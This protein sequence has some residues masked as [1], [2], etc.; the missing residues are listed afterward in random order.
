MAH[1]A[2][3][4]RASQANCGLMA[5]RRNPP[6]PSLT[7][8]LSKRTRSR[9]RRFTSRSDAHVVNGTRDEGFDP[10]V[11]I[12]RLRRP[13][14]DPGSEWSP[15]QFSLPTPPFAFALAPKCSLSP[16]R[17]WLL[18]ADRQQIRPQRSRVTALSRKGQLSV[19][20]RNGRGFSRT[21]RKV[22]ASPA[23]GR[24]RPDL[25]SG[26]CSTLEYPNVGQPPFY[27]RSRDSTLSRYDIFPSLF[28]SPS[29][30]IQL[31]LSC[32]PSPAG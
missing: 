5:R 24:G 11:A 6:R 7:G 25:V 21:V 12:A 22:P 13:A 31:Y 9:H 14:S 15:S 27:Y 32:C 29:P 3:F 18:S 28:L 10:S 30:P 19:P 26:V 17:V 2:C 20:N 8:T 1:G 4:R 23:A 16:Q